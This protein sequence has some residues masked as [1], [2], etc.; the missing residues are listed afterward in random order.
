MRKIIIVL[1]LGFALFGCLGGDQQAQQQGG[2]GTQDT[3]TGTQGT[4]S[5]IFDPAT[6]TSYSLA[7]AAGV[8][9]E[10]TA[11]I[12]GET[13][14]YW[15]KGSNMLISG[16]SGGRPFTG[17]LKGNDMYVKME[18]E[19]KAPYAQMGIACDWFLFKGEE[20]SGTSAHAV[21]TASYTAPNV[22]WSCTAAIFGDEKFAV[23]GN[24]CTMEDLMDAMQAQYP[25]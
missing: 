25:Q 24:A 9:L 2:T 6:A 3:G 15:I 23:S 14:K 19:D 10:C 16:T 20:G 12:N 8:P 22:Q 21:D 7:A 17:I 5:G 13:T 4:G 18:E 1:L 11:V